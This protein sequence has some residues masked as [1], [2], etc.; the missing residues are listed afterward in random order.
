[1]QSDLDSA[2]QIQPAARMTERLQRRYAVCAI[3]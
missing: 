3:D 2:A 1:L